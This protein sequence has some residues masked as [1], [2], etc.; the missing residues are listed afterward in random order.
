VYSLNKILRQPYNDTMQYILFK[1]VYMPLI[2]CGKKTSTIRVNCSV[3]EDSDIMFVSGQE[4]LQ[5]HINKIRKLSF[6]EITERVARTDGFESKSHLINEIKKLYPERNIT[7][8]YYIQFCL[9]T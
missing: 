5:V 8:I 9:K 3:K 1:K 6:T 2:R 4:K 7:Q